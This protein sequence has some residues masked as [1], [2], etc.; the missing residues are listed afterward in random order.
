MLSAFPT[1]LEALSSTATHIFLGEYWRPAEHSMPEPVSRSLQMQTL[2]SFH[3]EPT[4]KGHLALCEEIKMEK[5]SP[6]SPSRSLALSLSLAPALALRLLNLPN[7]RPRLGTGAVFRTRAR[8]RRVQAV[9]VVNILR[10]RILCLGLLAT[11]SG[12]VAASAFHL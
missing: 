3:W 10:G 6:H 5:V 12:F 8:H 9:A 11:R 7:R 4:S 2:S 1:A